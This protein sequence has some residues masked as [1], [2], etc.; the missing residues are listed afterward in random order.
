MC[1]VFQLPCIYPE[2][3]QTNQHEH[4]D[5]HWIDCPFAFR[6]N[7]TRL[8]DLKMICTSSYSF[9]HCSV[10]LHYTSSDSHFFFKILW[11]IRTSIHVILHHKI[12]IYRCIWRK[13]GVVQCNMIRYE[14]AKSFIYKHHNV[15][16]HLKCNCHQVIN[17]A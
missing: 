1:V 5:E 15:I 16:F 8:S 10:Y 2:T 4:S 17:S 3:G 14:S 7:A 9:I 6:C 12:N 11:R 13:S